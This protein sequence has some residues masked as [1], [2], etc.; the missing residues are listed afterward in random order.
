MTVLKL[1]LKYLHNEEHF[2]FMTDFKSLVVKSESKKLNIEAHFAEFLVKYDTENEVLQK[3]RKSDITSKISD[4]DS[5]RDELYRGILFAVK[6]ATTHFNMNTRAAA[7]R[8]SILTEK[9]G[10]VIRKPYNEETAAISTLVQ[11][12]KGAYATDFATIG[13]TDWIDIIDTKNKAFVELM[14][15]R[16][17]DLSV[18]TEFNMKEIRS[19]IDEIYRSIVTRIQALLI[20]TP[21][22]EL[23]T[24]VKELNVRIGKYNHNIALRKGRKID[25]SKLNS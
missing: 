7:E 8:V 21:S 9:A 1:K 25:D 12:A 19:E 10:D 11:E 14:N 3:I 16:Y 2:Q 5:E 4:M 13:L 15:N 6:S 23:E 24:F 22:P 17:S 20:I 18:Q